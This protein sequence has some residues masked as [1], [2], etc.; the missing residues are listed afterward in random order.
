M[1]QVQISYCLQTSFWG[2]NNFCSLK[3]TV[4][5]GLLLFPIVG[6][7]DVPLLLGLNA[8]VP[9]WPGPGPLNLKLPCHSP[10]IHHALTTQVS[11]WTCTKT[12]LSIL[13]QTVSSACNALPFPPLPLPQAH[14]V[15]KTGF[16]LRFVWLALSSRNKLLIIWFSL[17]SSFRTRG[18]FTC[19]V[20]FSVQSPRWLNF[21]LK[22]SKVGFW[23]THY[24]FL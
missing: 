13:A 17:N 18:E 5:W 16:E 8:N 22:V 21:W 14:M 23:C 24:I 20:N 7:P 4:I 2:R 12:W 3:T 1:D 19:Q 15:T 10:P 11:F 9:P 6:D